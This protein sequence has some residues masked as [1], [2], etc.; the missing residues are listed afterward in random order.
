MDRSRLETF[1]LIEK[2]L[3][4]RWE[5]DGL[6]TWKPHPKQE[7]FLGCTERE[8]W[9]LGANRFGKTDAT[10]FWASNFL[11][12]GDPD[13]RPAYIGQGAYIYDKAVQLRIY[14]KNFR[15]LRDVVQPKIFKNGYGATSHDPFIPES[16]ISHWSQ[17]F[18]TLRLRGIGSQATFYTYDA[19]PAGAAGAGLSGVVYDEPPP[20]LHYE[21][22]AIRLEVGR[23]LW[24][25]GG[26]TLLPDPGET[27]GVS[28]FYQAKIKPWIDTGK[29]VDGNGF[30]IFVGALRDNPYLTEEQRAEIERVYPP[31]TIAHRIRV[32][33]ELLPQIGGDLAYWA[34]HESLHDDTSLDIVP[35]FPL[36]LFCDFNVQPMVWEIGQ[37]VGEQWSCFDEIKID[38][39]ANIPDMV[40]M[41]RQKYPNPHAPLIIH[42]DSK[43][44]TRHHQTG[45]T[46]Y[47]IMLEHFEHYPAPIRVEVPAKAFAVEDRVAAMNRCLRGPQ[48]EVRFKLH[49]ER[50]PELKA[51]LEGVLRDKHG[52]LKKVKDPTD[53]Y[54]RRTHASDAVSCGITLETPV[55]VGFRLSEG[56]GRIPSPRYGRTG[57]TRPT[58]RI[59]SGFKIG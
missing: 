1:S 27:G 57:R 58:G 39:N 54:A 59:V 18:Q 41:F 38:D 49:P 3:R 17:Q 5:H 37:R 26:A 30:H 10:M 7:A 45:M 8:A 20:P 14:G 13:P 6:R 56:I 53:P 55:G 32:L 35:G 48:E 44:N 51:D 22:N 34:Y 31:G 25:R 2:E 21:E 43:G 50:C 16:E 33:G 42:G 29:N 52:G 9:L 40:W 4:R 11:R 15:H 24:I 46:D 28:W 47:H 12:T 36:R 19:D 23:R